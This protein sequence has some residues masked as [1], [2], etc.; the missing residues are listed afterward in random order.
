M[1]KLAI[2]VRD[3]AYD[4][5][6]TPLTFAYLYAAK[7]VQV[8]MLVLAGPGAAATPFDQVEWVLRAWSASTSRTPHQSAP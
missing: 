2:V 8:D 5:M 3:D 4:K 6:L 7:G 1:E